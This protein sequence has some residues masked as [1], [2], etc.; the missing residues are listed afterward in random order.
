[1]CSRGMAG[2][3]DLPWDFRRQN[4]LN[5][6]CLQRIT[7]SGFIM[8]SSGFPFSPDSRDQGP[9]QP[10]PVSYHRFLRFAFVHDELLAKDEN[11]QLSHPIEPCEADQIEKLHDHDHK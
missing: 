9:E 4:S 8:I 6:L 3:P 1:M 11:P 2:L 5:S 7:V 10:V